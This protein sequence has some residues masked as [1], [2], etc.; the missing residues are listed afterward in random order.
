MSKRRTV[1]RPPEFLRSVYT[2]CLAGTFPPK[3]DILNS[4]PS[5][6]LHKGTI[7]VICFGDSITAG[8]MLD[9]R[10]RNSVWPALVEKWSNGRYRTINE[11]RGGRSTDCLS[12]FKVVFERHSSAEI[13]LLALGANDARDT[14]SK[15]IPNAQYNIQTIVSFARALSPDIPIVLVGPPN[16]RKNTLGPTADIA[17]Q[18]EQNLIALNAMMDDLARNFGLAF[19]SL[20]GCLSEESLFK[21]GIHPD[22]AGN[23]I[24]ADRVLG[25][26]DEL[27]GGH[28]RDSSRPSTSPALSN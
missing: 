8:N 5:Q 21:D 13:L 27:F 9:S 14:T 6:D 10:E 15:C 25:V 26:F 23:K 2:R 4:L 22:V 24:I 19:F 28:H 16:L 20:F 12:E 18:R 17:E 11:G 1:H 3:I 7:T